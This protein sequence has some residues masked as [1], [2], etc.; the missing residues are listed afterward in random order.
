M[1]TLR[2]TIT[3]QYKN[4]PI[5][6]PRAMIEGTPQPK[7]YIAPSSLTLIMRRT[8]SSTELLAA[9]NRPALSTSTTVI[10]TVV[11]AMAAKAKKTPTMVP[12]A[13]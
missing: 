9:L 11:H 12:N 8:A 6:Q 2:A 5:A 4:A 3:A 10:A 7:P 13:A 1:P